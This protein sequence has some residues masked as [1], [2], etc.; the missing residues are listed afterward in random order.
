MIAGSGPLPFCVLKEAELHQ[1]PVSVAALQEE[2]APEIESFISVLSND[3]SLVWMGVGQL[4]KLLRLFRA[5]KV[6]KA[7]MVG[8]VKHV[9]IFAPG[10]RNPFARIKQ[11][12]DLKMI[13]LLSSLKQ[14]DTS[15]LISGVISAIEE[16]GIEFLDSSIML[17]GLL[18]E[19]GLMT[20]RAPTEEESR[21]IAYGRK[22]AKEIARL[23]IGQTI[24]VKS[25]A[26]VAVEAMEGTDATIRRAADLTAGEPLTVV[27]V[28]RPHQDMR[29]DLPVLGLG[30]LQVFEECNVTA[31]A[32]DA[33]KTLIIEKPDFLETADK[34]NLAVVG[35]DL[36]EED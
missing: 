24:V 35:L 23:D 27:K 15:S 21:D 25:Q 26:V 19:K 6:D 17:Q 36:N 5:E 1:I 29:F 28:S 2:T 32:V 8:Q 3:V 16:E 13:R 12:P 9:R 20:R 31:L 10:S 22:M 34:K 4:G 30:T 18:A 33:E 7:L 14:K 11:V